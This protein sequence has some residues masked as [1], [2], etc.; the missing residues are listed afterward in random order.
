MVTSTHQ[1]FSADMFNAGSLTEIRDHARRTVNN[2]P[3]LDA[4][5]HCSEYAAR[6]S[7][8][9]LAEAI[10]EVLAMQTEKETT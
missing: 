2:W 10:N 8:I 3:I 5:T 1:T 6:L 9:K 4:N 7:F